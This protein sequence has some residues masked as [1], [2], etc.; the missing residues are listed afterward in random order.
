MATLLLSAAG[1]ALGGGV[2]RL[3]RRAGRDA[4]SAR[5]SGATLGSAI[6]QRLLGAGLGAGRDRA[7][8][9]VPGHGVERGRAARRGSSGAV[10]RGRAGDL[11]E[12]VP[13]ERCSTEQVGGKGGGGATVREYSYS[14]SLAI[15]LCEGEVAAGRADL[16]GRAGDR[17]VGADLAAA[18]GRRGP[19]ARPADRG[20]RG[21]AGAGLSRD[22]LCR[23]REPR[24]DALRQPHPAVQ[25]RGVP[26][27]GGRAAGRAAAAG[28]RRAGRGAGAGDRGVRAG[29][30]AGA[31]PAGQGRDRRRQRAQRSRACR[32]SS[33]RSSSW[34]RNCRTCGRCRWWSA[35]SATTC[36]AA[37][38]RLRPAVE[39]RGEDGDADALGGVGAGRGAAAQVVSRVDGRPV[40]G[41]T[42][43]D[44]S[45]VQAIR[46]DARERAGGDVLSVHPD[47]HPGGQ[48]AARSVDRRGRPAGGAVA[49]A[50]HAGAGA[51]AGGLDRQDGG[52]GG[53]GRGVLR[54]GRAPAD[55][56]RRRTDGR[57]R[58]A[59][60]MV[61]TGGSS[62]TMRI[63]A[64]SRAASTP[65]ASGR[66]C[67]ALTQIRDAADGYPA[68]RALCALAEDVRAILGPGDQDRLC[69]RLVG[70]FRA[71]SGGR[72]G[73]RAL[74]PRSALGVPGDR[75]RRDRQ[76]HAAVG[77]A[78]RARAMPT[79]RRGRSTTSTIS[80]ATSRAARASTGTMPTPPGRDA[81]E[82]TPIADGA[83]GE[84][85]VFRYKDLVELV[86]EAAPSTGSAAS[87]P[88]APTA[89]VPQIEADLVHRARLPGG[90]Q[91]HE[92]AERLPRSEV[93][94]E[95]LSL[96][97]E[98][99]ARRLHP[100]SLSSGDVRAL[101]RSG[102][103]PASDV[104]GGRMVDMARAHVWA[105]DARPWPDFPGPAGDLGRRRRTTS[106]A[107]G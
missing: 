106:A 57:L 43:A 31:L 46:R 69:G 21:R 2:R 51:G 55:F 87:R 54:A 39:Q 18:R 70:V 9:A 65:S 81:Q 30:R 3:G 44:A 66:R 14:V 58:R 67:A 40:F 89:W 1:S 52:G 98:R 91:G 32:T 80:R 5:R 92:P 101:E 56:T 11:V 6:D 94:G 74:P 75:F 22:G 26:A 90:R 76:L 95:L 23:V 77:L 102:E 27:A 49:R 48:R 10:R 104:Y 41:G 45:V 35:G 82:R 19:A 99:L 50:D 71:P 17:S 53:R 13:R 60:G 72:V 38:A 42:P 88:A 37:A 61:A 83:Y 59:G 36:A 84:D 12:P 25:L 107:T 20:D 78:G 15:A 93:V 86:V 97:F 100:V 68:V 4:C 33:P 105:W 29:D 64:R 63:S 73:R 47:G 24:P 62:C 16:G 96:L 8:R 28:A 7:G 34:R 103:Q 79:R 85:W